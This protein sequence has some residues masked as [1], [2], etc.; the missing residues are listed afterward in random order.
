MGKLYNVIRT[1]F[2]FFYIYSGTV[3]GRWYKKI[4]EMVTLQYLI[5]SLL[6]KSNV[7]ENFWLGADVVLQVV[8]QEPEPQQGRAAP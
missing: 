2:C 8:Q 4:I 5:L 6:H 3:L 1:V 7:V